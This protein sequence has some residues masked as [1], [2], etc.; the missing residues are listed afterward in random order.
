MESLYRTLDR[1]YDRIAENMKKLTKEQ[2][3]IEELEATDKEA[4]EL[5]ECLRNTGDCTLELALP[6]VLRLPTLCF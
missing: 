6:L 1:L 3:T 5:I 4:K 2:V